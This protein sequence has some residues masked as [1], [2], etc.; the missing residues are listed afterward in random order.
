MCDVAGRIP[1]PLLRS[2]IITEHSCPFPPA[3]IPLDLIKRVEFAVDVARG[4][5]CLH[6]QRPT[7]IHRDLKPANLLVSARFEVKVS[8]FGL[9]RI[10]DAA[11]VSC[12][13]CP[14]SDLSRLGMAAPSLLAVKL[15][16]LHGFEAQSLDNSLSS[17]I[18]LCMPYLCGLTP[19]LH[20]PTK[21]I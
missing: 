13:G 21:N 12:P 18:P 16:P 6:A 3:G 7:I 10:K 8:D 11:Q 5:S 20:L 17:W 2:T 14:C 4:M 9:S 1:L 19:P 15:V